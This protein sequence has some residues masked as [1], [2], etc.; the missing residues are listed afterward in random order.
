[1]KPAALA[2]AVAKDPPP[3]PLFFTHPMRHILPVVAL[4]L[5]PAAFADTEPARDAWTG[6][7]AYAG[8]SGGFAFGGNADNVNTLDHGDLLYTDEVS[9]KRGWQASL[10]GGAVI[11]LGKAQWV[12]LRVGGEGGYTRFSLD[13]RRDA[14]SGDA[15]SGKAGF[16]RVGPAVAADFRIKGTPWSFTAGLGAGAAFLDLDASVTNGGVSR[17]ASDNPVTPYVSGLVSANYALDPHTDLTLGCR[18]ISLSDVNI[19]GTPATVNSR[20]YEVRHELQS[21]SAIELGLRFTF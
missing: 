21:S 11:P 20:V 3:P 9:A 12:R 5:A 17:N 15:I 6:A 1:M 4:C 7:D 19:K 8:A 18:I 13:S 16:W 10:E 2:T 14:F